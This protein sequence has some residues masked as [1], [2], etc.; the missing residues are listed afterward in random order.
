MLDN[1]HGLE[2]KGSKMLCLLVV[3]FLGLDFRLRFFLFYWHE[4]EN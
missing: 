4:F 2:T 3:D 1:V